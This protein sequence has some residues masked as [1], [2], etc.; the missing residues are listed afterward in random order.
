M[1]KSLELGIWTGSH[2]LL[3]CSTWTLKVLYTTYLIHSVTLAFIEALF[4]VIAFYLTLTLWWGRCWTADLHKLEQFL[5]NA[6]SMMITSNSCMHVHV[7]W[8]CCHFAKVLK[9]T[10]TVKQKVTGNP[11]NPQGTRCNELYTAGT[12]VSPG[13][14]STVKHVLHHHAKLPTNNY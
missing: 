12:P 1:G 8:M 2:I 10:Q 6:D 9:K 11:E 5:N 13:S 4:C 7:I 3:N 14:L